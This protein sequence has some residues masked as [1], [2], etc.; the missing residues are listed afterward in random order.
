MKYQIKGKELFL[1][2]K[3]LPFAHLAFIKEIG[4][5]GNAIVFLAEN[6]LL[7]RKEAVKIWIKKKW[8]IKVDEERFRE[9][10]KKNAGLNFP[11]IAKFYDARIE[12]DFYYARIEYISGNTLKEYLLD[13]PEFA[14]RYGILETII[15]T[16]DLVYDLGIYHGDLHTENI[17]VNNHIPFIIDFGTSI[18]S[19]KEFS[20]K[21]DCK[22][23]IQLCYEVLPELNKFNFI[24][25]DTLI[26]EG[27]K[28]ALDLMQYCLRMIWDI[29][30][31]I[32]T[33]LDN[34]TFK[35]WRFRFDVLV[36]EFSFLKKSIVDKFYIDKFKEKL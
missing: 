9:E 33:E 6:K 1:E 8:Q 36:E 21:R 12:N 17:I 2:D 23:L 18:F 24:D 32:I 34:Y 5:G 31:S 16:M 11:H 20:Q 29:E 4:K 30:N 13:M 35:E 3:K 14:Y 25:T 19:G 28:I 26:K 27:S 10:V 7:G 15:N 22:M